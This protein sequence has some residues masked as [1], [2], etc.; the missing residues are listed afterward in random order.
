MSPRARVA[1]IVAAVC[2]LAV[3]ATVAGALVQGREAGGEVHGQTTTEAVRPERPPL[4]LAV[5]DRDDAEARALRAAERAYERN[6]TAAAL[7][8][9][10]A[11]LARDPAS[12]EAAVGVA[13]AGGPTGTTRRLA[14]IVDEHPTSAVARLN[15]GLALL[16]DGDPEAAADEWREAE[17]RDPDSPAALR[18]EDLLN[19]RSPPGRPQFFLA[20]FPR[21]VE[22]LPAQRRLAELRARAQGGDARS[23]LALGSALESAGRRV[24][25][26]RAYDRALELDRSSLDARVAAALSRF[27][28]DDPSRAFSRLGPLASANP[29]A[30]VVRFHLGLM[31]L[32]LPDLEGARRQLELARE[33]A[34]RGYYGR[35]ARRILARLQQLE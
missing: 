23:W 2:V 26:Q 20:D 28:K 14:G 13:V 17:R 7:R 16:A 18:A 9:F 19:P 27:D 30:P 35:Q 4:E 15:H 34:P 6:D 8:R 24:S 22:R 3:G 25:A 11:V 21:D 31:L 12:V 33:E 32:W 10:R 29:E 1:A 5:L